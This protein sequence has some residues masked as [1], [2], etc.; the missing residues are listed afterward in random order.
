[1]KS[2]SRNGAAGRL[3]AA[4]VSA[5]AIG[6]LAFALSSKS[7]AADEAG[8]DLIALVVNLIGEKD[9]DLRAVG[10]EQVRSDAKGQ[11]A[12]KQF[13]A[14]LPKLSAD[15]QVGL[16]KA[17]ADRGDAA[18]R[19]AVLELLAASQAEPVRVATIEALGPLGEPDDLGRLVESLSSA[20][21]AERTAGRAS[22]VQ[23]RGAAVPPAIAAEMK[24]A[25]PPLRVALIEILVARHA[26]ETVPEI[27]SAAVDADPKVRMAAMTALG[28]LAE[29]DQIT[30]M[31]PGVLKAEKG[32]EREAAEKCVMFAC[33]RIKDPEQRAVPVLVAWDGLSEADRAALLPTLG[34]VGGPAALKIV[35]AAI[36]DSDGQRHAIG[37]RALCN[38][39]DASIAPRLIELAKT[40]PHPE[41]RTLA[42]AALIRVAPLPDKR[43]G[44]EK[45]ALLQTAMSMCQRDEERNQVLKRASAVRTIPTLHFI[46]GFLD[47]PPFAQQACESIVEMAHHREFREPNKA[48]FD[49]LLDRVIETSKDAVVVER[50]NRYKKGQTWVRPA[51]AQA[52]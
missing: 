34:R 7:L 28:Q 26:R 4:F 1:M 9:K 14:Q 47:Q 41:H 5:A 33:A 27:L 49:K 11:A 37:I 6:L 12:T 46:V 21:K 36:A 3:R 51:A 10:L 52:W 32:A 22:L 35:E 2:W 45:L 13:A 39:P 19:P 40:D 50:A 48:E 24:K 23:L 20:S 43:T 18:A 16:L 17:L 30:A 42:L 44:D 15:A 8:A 25:A 31:L 38:W 29:G